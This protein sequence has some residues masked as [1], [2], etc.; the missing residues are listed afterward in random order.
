MDGRAACPTC[1]PRLPRVLSRSDFCSDGYLYLHD[2]SAWS[3]FK[4]GFLD[5]GSRTQEHRAGVCIRSHSIVRTYTLVTGIVFSLLVAAHVARLAGEGAHVLKDPFFDI[6]TLLSLGLS[7]WALQL[8]L[9]GA[10]AQQ[11]GPNEA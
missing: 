10:R 8:L 2:S 5:A 9:G 6:S 1:S 4:G 11:P 7:L 3:F